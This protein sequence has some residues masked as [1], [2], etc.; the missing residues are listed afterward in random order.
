MGRTIL[1]SYQRALAGAFTR[2]SIMGTFSEANNTNLLSG[3]AGNNTIQ[4][5]TGQDWVDYSGKSGDYRIDRI[6]GDWIVTDTN[7]SDGDDGRDVLRN[8]KGVRFANGQLEFGTQTESEFLV[9]SYTAG[10]QGDSSITGLKSGG[11]VLT[12]SSSAQDGRDGGVYGQLYNAQGQKQGL[13]FRVNAHTDGSQV[14]STTVALADGGF[15]VS[16]MVFNEYFRGWE[17]Y[18]QRYNARG[19]AQGEEFRVNTNT[20]SDQ[21][22]PNMSALSDGGFVVTWGTLHEGNS[23]E[24]HAQ[25]YNAQGQTQGAEFRIDNGAFTDHYGGSITSLADGGFVVA[26]LDWGDY[27]GAPNSSFAQR[28]NAQGQTQGSVVSIVDRTQANWLYEPQITGLVNGG[29]LATW[30]WQSREGD[31][32][33]VV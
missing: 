25:R 9:N 8:V 6:N 17:I 21:M 23:R 24:I 20:T 16:W 2:G 26:W 15:A 14:A 32:K 33:S 12:W 11:F 13:E 22:Y 1:R 30:V 10:N 28:Y 5:S 18:A 19:Q 29:F 4:G 31:R 3:G 7:L 27:G